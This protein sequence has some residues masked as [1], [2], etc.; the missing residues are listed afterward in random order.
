MID[1]GET[2]MIV[3]N[4]SSLNL[5]DSELMSIMIQTTDQGDQNILLQLDY[6]LDYE[7]FDTQKRV[8]TFIRCWGAKLDMHFRYSGSDRIYESTETDD[9]QFIDEVRNKY[10]MANIIPTSRLRH[11]VITTGLSGSQVDI[12]AEELSIDER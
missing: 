7:S 8:L 2:E 5:H 6:I 3:E 12:I 11:F 9:S 10:A 4:I 1:Y